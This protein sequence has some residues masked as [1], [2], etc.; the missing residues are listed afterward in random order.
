[1]RVSIPS[2]YV[3]HN[4]EVTGGDERPYKVGSLGDFGEEGGLPE[5][6]YDLEDFNI[7]MQ[8]EDRRNEL[9]A[10]AQDFETSES[11]EDEDAGINY[12]YRCT[13]KESGR[14]VYIDCDQPP[15]ALTMR[16]DH[17]QHEGC[18]KAHTKELREQ[19]SLDAFKVCDRGSDIPP[20]TLILKSGWRCVRKLCPRTG[21]IK[22][23]KSRAFLKGYAM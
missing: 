19:V 2:A 10:L 23:L 14:A 7:T 5:F 13:L 15:I 11:I 22:R 18:L 21:A 3:Y 6:N 17:P 12:V 20:G 1:M 4:G 9:A 16:R 8:R